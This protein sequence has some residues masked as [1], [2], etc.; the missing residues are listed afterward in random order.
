MLIKKEV[1]GT[2]VLDNGIAYEV[3]SKRREH[4][5]EKRE[6]GEN[7]ERSGHCK[8]GVC[9]LIPLQQLL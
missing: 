5:T 9:F 4:F 3:F 1:Y 7:P 2:V 6:S 8:R